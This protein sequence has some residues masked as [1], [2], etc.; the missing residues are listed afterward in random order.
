MNA[1]YE[2]LVDHNIVGILEAKAVAIVIAILFIIVLFQ[3]GLMRS[4]FSDQ[5]IWTLCY[6]TMLLTAAIGFLSNSC[7]RNIVFLNSNN[8]VVWAL[9]TCIVLFS[10]PFMDIQNWQLA[11]KVYAEKKL[12]AYYLAGIFFAFY[13]SLVFVLGWVSFNRAMDI[14]LVIVVICVA[15]STINNAIVGMQRIAGC[16][17]G[18]IIAGVC[19]AGWQIVIPMK[20]MGLWLTIGTARIY[21]ICVCILIAFVWN[22][23]EKKQ[24]KK[25]V[26][27]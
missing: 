4:V 9:Y 20:V 8:D 23:C 1:I 24:G 19:V 21:M 2:V 3:N 15:T 13:M 5:P 27:V 7:N 12:H 11:K 17:V 6:I 16:K 14:L 18:V 10:G 25:E 26:N 22:F